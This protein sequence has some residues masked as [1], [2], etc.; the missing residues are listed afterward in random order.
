MRRGGEY[1]QKEEKGRKKR[2]KEGS[3]GRRKAAG[4]EDMSTC[5]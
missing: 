1:K 2:S 5:Q 3:E 4:M